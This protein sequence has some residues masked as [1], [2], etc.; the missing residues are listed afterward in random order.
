VYRYRRLTPDQKK[1]AVKERRLRRMP[2]H[3]PPHVTSDTNWYLI[4]A[5]VYEHKPL[6]RTDR[7][8]QALCEEFR[9]EFSKAQIHCAAWVILPN[10]HHHLLQAASRDVIRTAVARVHGRTSKQ[11]NDLRGTRGTRNWCNYSD[12]AMRNEQHYW[13]TLNYIHYNPVKHGHCKRMSEWL[14]SSVHWY[15]EHKGLEWLGEIWREHPLRD[16]GKGWDW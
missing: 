6:F 1:D 10:H 7:E 4:S 16:Y 3:A 9:S 5:A 8:R 15:A 12:R 14:V 2:L 13:T 11:L